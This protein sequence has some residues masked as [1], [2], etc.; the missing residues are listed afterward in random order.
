M[1]EV[2][3]IWKALFIA[4][5]LGYLIGTA[6]F[7]LL[8]FRRNR[9]KRKIFTSEHVGFA[10]DVN[11]ELV[12][13]RIGKN[14]WGVV[15]W[16]IAFLAFLLI[17][18]ESELLVIGCFVYMGALTC[19]YHRGRPFQNVQSYLL[20][21]RG[22]WLFPENLGR[23]FWKQGPALFT[24]WDEIIGYKIDGSF[25]Q[26]SGEGDAVAQVEYRAADYV[27]VKEALYELGVDRLELTDRL[28]SA[29]VDEERFYAAEDEVN[30]LGWDL[31]D[32]FHDELQLMNLRPEFGVMRNM[33]GDRLFDEQARSWLQLNLIDGDSGERIVGGVFPLW[34]ST[35]SVGYLLGTSGQ[36]LIDR[37]QEWIKMTMR[38][39]QKAR[40]VVVS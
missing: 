9:M 19:Y 6:A 11:T 31:L 14:Y 7:G 33:P 23:P 16:T 2:L 26:F 13:Y 1:T 40:E 25:I 18:V 4:G 37:L 20:T 5:V 17:G 21:D 35:G 28:W 24:A 34:H 29:Q 27:R 39:A 12:G 32:L 30:D 3:A 10:S 15:L 36:E 38:D 22:V 8:P